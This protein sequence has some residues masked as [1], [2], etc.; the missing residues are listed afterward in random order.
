M[1]IRWFA[2]LLLLCL[3]LTGCAATTSGGRVISEVEHSQAYSAALLPY[4]P[5]YEEGQPRDN[6]YAEVTAGNAIICFDVQAVPAMERGVG[7]YWYPHVLSTMVIAVDRN[8]TNAAITGWN[9]LWESGVS[10]G[11]GS[12]STIRNMLV[13]GSMSYGLNNEKPGR[14]RMR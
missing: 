1:R 11:I 10:V 6:L 3:L 12:D 14:K 7:K 5:G 9:S 13:L 2:L 4:L 8:R